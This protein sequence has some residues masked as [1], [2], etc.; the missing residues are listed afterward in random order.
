MNIAL[1]LSAG[2]GTR[3]NK[4][5]SPKQFF[6]LNGKPMLLY[7]MDLFQEQSYIDGFVVVARKDLVHKTKEITSGYNKCM[8]VIE[9]GERRQDSVS[10]AL[11][12]INSNAKNCKVVFIHD[13]AR[14]FCSS[15][16][17]SKLYKTSMEHKAV[18][19]V[20]KSEDTLKELNGSVVVRTL[21]R[22]VIF[23]VQTPQ[24]FDFKL[25]YE[26]YNSFPKDTLATDDAY[27]LEYLGHE[28]HCIEGEKSNIKVTYLEDVEQIGKKGDF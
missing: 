10:N 15:N 6:E 21:D 12:W 9:G 19:P 24:I 28:V 16:L 2:S 1:I 4:G 18:I 13:A 25:L 23:R 11:D 17:V 22:N 26:C 7:S 5:T 8:S 3:F 20:L 14:P 27:L